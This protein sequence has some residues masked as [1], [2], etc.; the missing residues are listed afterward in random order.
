M[1][2]TKRIILIFIVLVS[3]VGCD[4]TTKSV[5][6]SLLSGTEGWS[7]LG[8]TIR[9]QLALNQG[10]FLGLGSS[11]PEMWRVG[12]FS[13]GAAGMLLILL[14]YTLFSKA[15]SQTAIFA[16]ALVFAGG[17]GNLIDRLM[18][19]GYVIDFIN[20]GVGSLR[21]G[22]FNVADIAVTLGLLIIMLGTSTRRVVQPQPHP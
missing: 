6:Q 4:Q 7:F 15:V 10:A 11:F 14:G 9:L 20:I 21:T 19:D 13:T 18:Y 2:I 17:V 8:G 3:C 22:I 12:I 16:Y 1:S 5:A